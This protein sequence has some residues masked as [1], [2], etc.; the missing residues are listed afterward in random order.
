MTK[1]GFP[2]RSGNPVSH[3]VP[4]VKIPAD[5][6]AQ[7][8]GGFMFLGSLERKILVDLQVSEG[9][10]QVTQSGMTNAESKSRIRSIWKLQNKGLVVV[11]RRMSRNKWPRRIVLWAAL[12]PLGEQFVEVF[13]TPLRSGGRIHGKRFERETGQALP[14]PP[15]QRR[16]PT[17]LVPYHEAARQRRRDSAPSAAPAAAAQ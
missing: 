10:Q 2:A 9:P 15:H 8:R 6:P 13:G 4:G 12:T 3:D 1:S 11:E 17:W 14:L 5:E 16:F 7:M